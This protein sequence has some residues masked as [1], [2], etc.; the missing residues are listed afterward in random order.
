MICP[1][2]EREVWA[3]CAGEHL[4]GHLMVGEAALV[5]LPDGTREIYKTVPAVINR[6]TEEVS[7]TVSPAL[8]WL[9]QLIQEL[10]LEDFLNL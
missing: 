9:R 8:A 7:P 5:S 1:I 3:D 4:Q 2:C 10:A 6:E